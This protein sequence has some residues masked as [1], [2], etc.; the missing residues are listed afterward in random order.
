[1]QDNNENMQGKVIDFNP[2]TPE[3]EPTMVKFSKNDTPK[4]E[5]PIEKIERHTKMMDPQI[6]TNIRKNEKEKAEAAAYAEMVDTFM[7]SFV[8]KWNDNPVNKNSQLEIR[9][10]PTSAPSESGMFQFCLSLE[11]KKD[12]I[13]RVL[14]RVGKY[15]H[16]GDAKAMAILTTDLYRAMF[17]E[18]A[19][20]GMLV[21]IAASDQR[22]NTDYAKIQQN[23]TI[24]N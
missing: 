21:A 19:H 8:F 9:M 7:Q 23:A 20:S 4:V 11:V 24:V 16:G 15:A 10:Q 14:T 12:G 17:V 1:M 3:A 13:W 5:S 18:I 6:L 22:E 2:A